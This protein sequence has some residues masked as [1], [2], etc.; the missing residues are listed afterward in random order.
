MVDVLLKCNAQI[1]DCEPKL[2]LNS[3]HDTVPRIF[4]CSDGYFTV[5][6][7]INF[8][9]VDAL[10]IRFSDKVYSPRGETFCEICDVIIDGIN[11]QHAILNSK[12][13]PNYDEDFYKRFSPPDYYQPGTKFYLNGLL[14][15]EIKLPIWKFY[16]DQY[17]V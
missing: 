12:Q 5:T 2:I 3:R 14:E 9:S 1:I 16:M 4:P 11:L 15:L 13:Y 6:T 17:N 10:Q 8:S 7:N